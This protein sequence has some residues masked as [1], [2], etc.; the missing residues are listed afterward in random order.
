MS[1]TKNSLENSPMTSPS[2]STGETTK[3]MTY[4]VYFPE[5]CGW[6]FQEKQFETLWKLREA[7]ALFRAGWFQWLL[8]MIGNT[9]WFWC[10]VFTVM[11]SSIIKNALKLWRVANH[12][13][14]PLILCG[15]SVP[16]RFAWKSQ[17]SLE[18]EI[19]E[20][21][22]VPHSCLTCMLIQD[23]KLRSWKAIW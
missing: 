10:A 20:E 5:S 8:F 15:N 3:G 13:W 6:S 17:N 9:T 18:E 4:A 1:Y 21:Y 22:C 7:W 23:R 16:F 11:E 14:F 19:C 2:S 12:S